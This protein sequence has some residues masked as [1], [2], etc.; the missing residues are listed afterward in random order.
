MTF[1]TNAIRMTSSVQAQLLPIHL[2]TTFK[3]IFSPFLALFAWQ[4]GRR[5]SLFSKTGQESSSC[6]IVF[7]REIRLVGVGLGP[8]NVVHFLE[9]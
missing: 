5:S 4:L 2:S 3:V 9:L 1:E 7:R 6:L 8:I